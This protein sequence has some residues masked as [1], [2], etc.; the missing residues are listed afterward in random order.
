MKNL[1]KSAFIAVMALISYTG[2]ATAQAVSFD[3]IS[4]NLGDL[5]KDLKAGGHGGPGG[6]FNHPP[7]PPAP[8]PHN[9][10]QGHGDN[11]GNH[12]G[13]GYNNGH[14]N[15]GNH[16]GPGNNNGW[17][18]GHNGNNGWNNGH[19]G[20]NNGHW[21]PQ[22]GPWNPQPN[23][24]HPGP[25]PGPWNPQPNPW[26]PGP[27]PGPANWHPHHNGH[28]DWNNNDWSNNHWNQHG[29]NHN[30]WWNNYS[31]WWSNNVHPYSM[32]RTVCDVT[33]GASA[34]GYIVERTM[35]FYGRATFYYYNYFDSL[36]SVSNTVSGVYSGGNGTPVFDFRAPYGADRCFMAITQ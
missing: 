22:P 2:F 1:N 4:G 11:G 20:N 3:A 25:Q 10:G 18:N 7:K 27:Q 15:P 35:P 14:N 21:N 9:G 28:P 6:G 26:N 13:P 36:I 12:N 24:W 32:Y 31:F 8:A 33:P 16:N 30:A 34:K 19:N 5:V 17:D 29:P 23:P